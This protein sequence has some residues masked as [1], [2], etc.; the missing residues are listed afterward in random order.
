LPPGH[1]A[2]ACAQALLQTLPVRELRRASRD[3]AGHP[4]LARL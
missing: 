2:L 4:R 1:L 3:V